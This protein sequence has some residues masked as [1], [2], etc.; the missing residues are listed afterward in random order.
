MPGECPL[1][2]GEQ[3]FDLNVRFSASYVR[4]GPESGRSD[5]VTAES[6]RD[7][8]RTFLASIITPVYTPSRVT[9]CLVMVLARLASDAVLDA[10]YGWLPCPAGC[11]PPRLAGTG[12]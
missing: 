7:P 10:A 8:L 9:D 2:G 5:T 4:F 1:S 3:T 6:A 11:K 12:W